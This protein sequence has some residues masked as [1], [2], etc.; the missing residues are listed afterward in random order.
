[1]AALRVPH[2][3]VSAVFAVAVA[4]LVYTSEAAAGSGRDRVA[5]V[6]VLHAGDV[7]TTW[8]RNSLHSLQCYAARHGY[9]FIP[10][11]AP[12]LDDAAS[13]FGYGDGDAMADAGATGRHLM[14][15]GAVDALLAFH[16]QY[17]WILLLEGGSVVTNPSVG[18]DAFVGAGQARVREAG[19]IPDPIKLPLK[20][21]PLA[22]DGAGTL[23]MALQGTRVLE[24]GAVL[25]GSSA[26]A[27]HIL[28]EWRWQLTQAG[29]VRMPYVARAVGS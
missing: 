10:R 26:C 20:P 1:M 6:S 22:C 15:L 3:A 7:G 23:S 14:A 25:I 16:S 2:H 5:I 9:A 4:W 19:P 27:R 13:A 18:L 24:S 28:V 21:L 11:V 12:R 8:A 17:D 29:S